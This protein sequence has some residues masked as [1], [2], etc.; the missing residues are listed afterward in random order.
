L[1]H[2]GLTRIEFLRI[3][4]FQFYNV[5]PQQKNFAKKVLCLVLPKSYVL[6]T[7]RFIPSESGIHHGSWVLIAFPSKSQKVGHGLSSQG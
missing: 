5:E 1:I 7:Y 6:Y 2:F 4:R 3:A